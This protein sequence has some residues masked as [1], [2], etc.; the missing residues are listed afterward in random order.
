L[1]VVF[2]TVTDP[3]VSPEVVIAAAEQAGLHG[4]RVVSPAR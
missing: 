2:V 4:V 1:Q 3:S